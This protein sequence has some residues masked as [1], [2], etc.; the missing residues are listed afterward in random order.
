MPTQSVAEDVYD[1]SHASKINNSEKPKSFDTIGDVSACNSADR[2]S[3]IETTIK[4][5]ISDKDKAII[6]TEI[7]GFE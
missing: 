4:K 1:A 2:V 5:Q 7:T 3:E 6:K